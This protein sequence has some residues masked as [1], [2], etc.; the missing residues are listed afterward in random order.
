MDK[1]YAQK[2]QLN[3]KRATPQWGGPLPC[4]ISLL[5]DYIHGVTFSSNSGS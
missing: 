1:E 2:S 5:L 4:Y 3:K